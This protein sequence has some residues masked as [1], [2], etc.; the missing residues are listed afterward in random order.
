MLITGSPTKLNS[1]K[2]TKATTPITTSALSTRRMTKAVIAGRAPPVSIPAR[3]PEA[4]RQLG[5]LGEA[6]AREHRAGLRLRVLED[7]RL[8][9]RGDA[10]V[11]HQHAPVD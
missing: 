11:H 8:V 3:A 6:G 10:P 1:A 2:A 9:D 4:G 7:G 5:E